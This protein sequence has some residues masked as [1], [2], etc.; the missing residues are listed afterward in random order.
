MYR[1]EFILASGLSQVLVSRYTTDFEFLFSDFKKKGVDSNLF[2]SVF[3]LGLTDIFLF[4]GLPQHL[5][6]C[7]SNANITVF[8]ADI[9]S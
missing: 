7:E 3:L 1:Q 4:I 2:F 9:F 8:V 6:P 5:C